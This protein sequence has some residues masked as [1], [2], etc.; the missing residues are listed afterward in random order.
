MTAP[1]PEELHNALCAAMVAGDPAELGAILADEFTL[2]H[3]TGYVQSG[4]SH[5]HVQTERTS[6]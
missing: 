3:M 2:T 6:S 1:D 4:K 5:F